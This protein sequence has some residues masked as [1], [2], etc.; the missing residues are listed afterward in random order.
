MLQ[1]V[2]SY[3]RLKPCTNYTGNAPQLFLLGASQLAENPE[4]W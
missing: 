4:S 1:H 2:E 3:K